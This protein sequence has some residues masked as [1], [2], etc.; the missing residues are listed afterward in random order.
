[1]CIRDRYR[2]KGLDRA[3]DAGGVLLQRL[4]PMTPTHKIARIHIQRSFPEAASSAIHRL[5]PG[6]REYFCRRSAER[7]HLHRFF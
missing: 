5:L 2:A 4:G 1:M 6:L 3:S 7:P